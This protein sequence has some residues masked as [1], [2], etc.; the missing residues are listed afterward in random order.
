M[1]D[2]FQI[3]CPKCGKDLKFPEKFRGR[4]GMC[5]FCMHAFKIPAVLP[6]EQPKPAA[7]PP[8]PWSNETPQ[9]TKINMGENTPNDGSAKPK[10]KDDFD[11]HVTDYIKK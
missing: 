1:E 8:D 11:F 10:P 2:K 9:T 3:D 5:P 6:A 7:K 4:T